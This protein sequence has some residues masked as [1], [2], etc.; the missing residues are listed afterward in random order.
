MNRYIVSSLEQQLRNDPT[1]RVFLRLAEEFRK[2]GM[3]DKAVRVCEDGLR[4]HSRYVPAWV[5]LGRCHESLSRPLEAEKAFSKVLEFSS[6]NPHALRGLG[7][8]ALNRRQ[9]DEARL[10]F[11]RLLIQEP[12]DEQILDWLQQCEDGALQVE[13]EQMAQDLDPTRTVEITKGNRDMIVDQPLADAEADEPPTAFDAASI[14][15][16]GAFD[17]N[18]DEEAPDED[19]LE[20]EMLEADDD[21]FLD[22]EALDE[23]DQAEDEREAPVRDLDQAEDD[24]EPPVREAEQVK[25][26]PSAEELEDAETMDAFDELEA[27]ISDSLPGLP[28]DSDALQTLDDPGDAV[29]TEGPA[30]SAV[31]ESATL[32]P[33]RSASEANEEVAEVASSEGALSTFEITATD[34]L[35][36]ASESAATWP[37]ETEVAASAADLPESDL[38][39][40]DAFEMVEPEPPVIEA[41]PPGAEVEPSAFEADENDTADVETSVNDLDFDLN[42]DASDEAEKTASLLADDAEEGEK[43][44]IDLHFE[45]ALSG[46]DDELIQDDLV[47]AVQSVPHEPPPP[48]DPLSSEEF[49]HKMTQG[50][51]HEKMEHFE[52]AEQIYRLLL[53]HRPGDVVVTGHLHRLLGVLS[54][55]SKKRKK[56]RKLSNWLDKIKGVYDVS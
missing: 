28:M 55:E 23:V 41:E 51:K 39:D 11:E 2:G 38:L 10:Y 47:T 49:E 25:P 52:Q 20:A 46:A 22:A 21:A 48:G 30:A 24:A 17:T 15:R 16:V 33:E 27:T 12:A 44:A 9:F 6:D 26:G 43:D 18:P 56:I 7:V 34:S 31:D 19:A 29:F 35:E 45:R 53:R 40:D 13:A 50:L 32:P 8:I 37:G 36:S 42:P 3:Y 5:C 1:S 14:A 54:G 4:H